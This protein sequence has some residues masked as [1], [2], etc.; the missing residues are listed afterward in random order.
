[1]DRHLVALV[2]IGLACLPLG[3]T[4]APKQPLQLDLLFERGAPLPETAQV[5]A[6]ADCPVGVVSV[7]DD[8][9]NKESIGDAGLPI[10]ATGLVEWATEAIWS[11]QEFGHPVADLSA[12]SA[13]F[14]G[15]GL[16]VAV[17]KAYC[18][19]QPRALRGSVVLSVK[20]LKGTGALGQR[21]YRGEAVEG[22]NLLFGQTG[23]GFSVETAQGVLNRAFRDALA[24]IHLDI[25]ALS[26]A[27]E[28]E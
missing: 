12:D 24:Q 1:M 17:T 19:S 14:A 7:I 10:V 15:L 20:Y 4:P 26:R 16:E 22:K 5:A 28:G 21:V 25:I 11:L 13:G 9:S 18:R 8:R 27:G 3:C 6:A 23:T 2:L